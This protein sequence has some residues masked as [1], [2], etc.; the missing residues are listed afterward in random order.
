MTTA[1]PEHVKALTRRFPHWASRRRKITNL[2]IVDDSGN[3]SD[4]AAAAARIVG[5][6]WRPKF[7]EQ[8]VHLSLARI[9]IKEHI[10]DG[11]GSFLA[12]AEPFESTGELFTNDS[13]AKYF[14]GFGL[15]R[16][17]IKMP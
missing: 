13:I 2:V 12:S 9:A 6:F 17:I 7:Q 14:I 1:L 4:S 5:N 8:E 16:G 10:N 3:I 15:Q 11:N